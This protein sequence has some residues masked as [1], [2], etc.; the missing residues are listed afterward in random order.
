MFQYLAKLLFFIIFSF[1]NK[2][3]SKLF[4]ETNYNTDNAWIENILMN[5][6]DK[7]DEISSKLIVKETFNEKKLYW[8]E[9]NQEILRSKSKEA[10]HLRKIL[11]TIESHQ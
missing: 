8:K 6:H 7:N 2:Q 11:N 10:F 9:L 3:V 1:L 5:F 4:K